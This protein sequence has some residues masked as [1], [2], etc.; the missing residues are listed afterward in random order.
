[1]AEKLST[2]L[3]NSL[4]D[5]DCLKNIFATAEIRFYSGSVPATADAAITG[6]VIAVVK[7]GG[8]DLTWAA[9]AIGGVL[10]KG[11]TAWTD[12]AAT[13]GVATHYRLV[14]TS[15]DDSSDTGVTF[16]RIQGTV[17]TGASDMNL[18]STTIASGLLTVNYFHQAIVP[19]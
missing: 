9:A 5:T 13:G 19:S 1:M 10:T 8:S 16:P 4:L 12:P 15:D 7:Q 17:G 14:D 2:F 6:A 11:A 18:V 3:C